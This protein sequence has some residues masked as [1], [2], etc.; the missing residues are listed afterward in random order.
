MKN[1]RLMYDRWWGLDWE[2]TLLDKEFKYTVFKS[3]CTILTSNEKEYC[4]KQYLP[5]NETNPQETID[6]FFKLVMLQ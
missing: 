4:I 3:G 2:I 1:V 5:L 6:K